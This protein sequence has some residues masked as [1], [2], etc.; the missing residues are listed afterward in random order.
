MVTKFLSSED[1]QPEVLRQM[2]WAK[3][4]PLN[5]FHSKW[6][7]QCSCL[8]TLPLCSHPWPLCPSRI[9]RFPDWVPVLF[10]GH[11]SQ[12]VLICRIY[13]LT[14][15]FVSSLTRKRQM[16][17]IIIKPSSVLLWKITVLWVGQIF[18]TLNIFRCKELQKT[19]PNIHIGI[20]IYTHT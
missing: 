15:F 16:L 4:L 13:P 6:G 2:G 17:G 12:D 1:F 14:C 3:A 11:W 18:L 19:K 5:T 9:P 8:S 10:L 20:Y 7:Q